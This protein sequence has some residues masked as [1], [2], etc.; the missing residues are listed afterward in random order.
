MYRNLTKRIANSLLRRI[1]IPA[2]A[3][4]GLS[5]CSAEGVASLAPD[6]YGKPG[7]RLIQEY[8][9]GDATLAAVAEGIR[10]PEPRVVEEP[11][12]FVVRLLGGAGPT[13]S[14]QVFEARS[15]LRAMGYDNGDELHELSLESLADSWAAL[16]VSVNRRDLLE[17][18]G[19]LYEP[20]WLTYGLLEPRDSY[21][22][23]LARLWQAY[24]EFEQTTRVAPLIR[25]H[26]QTLDYVYCLEFIG[27]D[28]TGLA[29]A[30]L[31]REAAFDPSG[32]TSS[33]AQVEAWRRIDDL[34]MSDTDV[35][36]ALGL[37]QDTSWSRLWPL[38]YD[39]YLAHEV[40]KA[41]FRE[42]LLRWVDDNDHLRPATLTI[43]P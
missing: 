23:F 29:K 30:F 37:C 7:S 6:A 40:Q 35:S 15:E 22:G 28:V 20:L 34:G 8:L 41:E 14:G 24:W 11:P 4:V 26:T 36:Q 13:A 2:L 42:F 25:F 32:T 10:L 1:L 3:S 19:E 18:F 39:L 43:V 16:S 9:A 5:A 17:S 21:H 38:P 31:L 27:A 12:P 33:P